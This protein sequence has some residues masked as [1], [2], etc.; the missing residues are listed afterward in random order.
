MS[1]SE[2]LLAEAVLYTTS[3]HPDREWWNPA[4]ALLHH[5]GKSS[6][7]LGDR[8][9]VLA[10]LLVTLARDAA[11]RA[12]RDAVGLHLVHVKKHSED[13]NNRVVGVLQFLKALLSV[14][15]EDLDALL[16]RQ[17]SGHVDAS[18]P[19]KDAFRNAH[20]WF[21]HIVR[22][23]DPDVLKRANLGALIARGAAVM[24]TANGS[25]VDLLIPVVFDDV[26][27]EES[28]SAILIQVQ[29][30]RQYNRENSGRELLDVMD[31]FRL[32]L[33]PTA[34][35]EGKEMD[36][37]E[38]D[39]TI[40]IVVKP[41]VR[42]VFTLA[43]QSSSPPVVLV[44]PPRRRHYGKFTAYDIWCNGVAHKQR[45]FRVADLSDGRSWEGLLY[46]ATGGKESLT[47]GNDG[48]GRP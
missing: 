31:P 2:P 16:P 41:V 26:L 15:E 6:V 29:N 18:I 36:L 34:E 42:M 11:L 22:A 33:F 30:S 19:M 4:A 48:D 37:L 9:E 32:G 20:I 28:I 17:A 13:G 45:V 21:N 10:A 5:V 35:R 43:A 12:R 40:G 14:K 8:G 1:P 27:K 44:P 46:H 25:G 38:W 3:L 47:F 23:T 7:S 24:C 39:A